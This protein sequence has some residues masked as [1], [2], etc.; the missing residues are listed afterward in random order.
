MIQK[1]NRGFT[2]LEIAMAITFLTFALVVLIGLQSA[3]TK[4]ALRDRNMQEA[5]LM[6]RSVLSA[7][8]LDTDEV[9]VQDTEMVAEDLVKRLL[10][11]KEN[12]DNSEENKS[13]REFMAHLK[14]EEVVIPIDE[15]TG[16]IITMKKL[17]LRISWGD[18]PD[19]H[20]DTY[21]FIKPK[22]S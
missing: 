10:P 17:F 12:L 9:D 18:G 16:A 14:V 5:M 8:E 19:D 1:N 20:L 2:L 4:K 13:R 6:A 11:T 3:A 22:V 7:V 15:Q 21:F